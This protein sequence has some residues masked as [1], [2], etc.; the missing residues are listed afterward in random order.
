MRIVVA[1]LAALLLLTGCSHIPG[2]GS[3]GAASPSAQAAATPAGTPLA[4]ATGGL[5]AEVAMP[6]GFPSD[7][8]VYPQARLTAGAQFASTGQVAF[9]MEWETKDGQTAVATYYQKEFNQGDWVLTVKDTT[10][11]P[12]TA[13]IARKTNSHDAGTLA[14]YNDSPVTVIALSLATAS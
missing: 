3:K 7:V 4:K 11:S 1:A 8:P 13:T 9:G 6:S 14:I 12:W 5:D 10:S 2:M